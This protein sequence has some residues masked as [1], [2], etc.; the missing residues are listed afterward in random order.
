MQWQPAAEWEKLKTLFDDQGSVAIAAIE[1]VR[2]NDEELPAVKERTYPELVDIPGGSCT[3]GSTAGEPDE[4]PVHKVTISPFAI[5][6]YPVTNEEFE[7]FDPAHHRFRDSFSWR[8]REPV[9]YISWQDAARYCNWLSRQNGL[10]P[11]YDEKNWTADLTANGFRLPTEAEWEY[12]ASGRGE[13]RKYPWGS[14]PPNE[15]L[16][17]FTSRDKALSIDP[18]TLSEP[19]TE[20]VEVVGSF[21]DGA[22]RDG[23]F[24]LCGNV[25]QWCTD[26]YNPY[27]PGDQ[28]DPCNLKPSDYRVMRGGSFGYYNGSQRCTGREFNTQVYGGYIY[29]GLRVALPHSSYEKLAQ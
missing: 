23:V 10:T 5:G 16:G 1:L 24:D 4:L 29:I 12:V 25:C 15:T 13:G 20:R 2:V 19:E 11:V 14:T 9:I 18:L 27:S 6:K 3:I 7:R 28:Q 22:G 8:D 17:K 21:P 26:W